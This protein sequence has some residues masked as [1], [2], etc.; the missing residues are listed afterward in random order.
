MNKIPV[1]HYYKDMNTLYKSYFL[2]MVPILIYGFYKNGVF[3]YVNDL[4]SFKDMLIPLYFYG[5]SA[6][7]G[8][9]CAVLGQVNVKKNI[10]IALICGASISINTNLFIY[11]ILLFVLLFIVNFIDKKIRLPFNKIAL[12]R[13]GLILALLLGSYSY[14]NIS[15]KLGKF[16]YNLFDIFIGKGISGIA[17]SSIILLIVS[18]I[19]L[20]VNKYYKKE[21]AISAIGMFVLSSLIYIVGT[22]NY[23][24]LKVILNGTVY[25][26]LVFVAPDIEMSPVH[27]RGMVVYGTIIGLVT[28][29]LTLLVNSF[30]AGIMAVLL[31]SFSIPVINKIGNKKY[32]K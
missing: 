14:M 17:T 26:S 20:S 30:E 5:I 6:L 15:E 19:I 1:L 12:V 29:I 25:F 10:L 4:I 32:L 23:D 13:L 3:L 24:F 2:A 7:I 11:P 18:L 8:F 9:L 22:Q 21:I 28:F 27:K 31:V 16:N